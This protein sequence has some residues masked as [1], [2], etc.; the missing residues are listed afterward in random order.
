MR[1]LLPTSAFDN[2]QAHIQ[3]DFEKA[4]I[5]SYSFSIKSNI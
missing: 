3:Y 1:K 5:L 4:I 2:T